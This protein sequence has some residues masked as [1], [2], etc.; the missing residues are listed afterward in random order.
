MEN[1]A[2]IQQVKQNVET[3]I[4]EGRFEEAMEKCKKYLSSFPDQKEIVKL[5][6]TIEE[7]LFEQ[8]EKEI[9]QKNK[10]SE[11]LYSAKDYLGALR[12]TKEALTLAPHNDKSKRLYLK[13]QE[14]YKAQMEEAEKSFIKQR[15]E[16]FE[17]LI[18]EEK[19]TELIEETRKLEEQNLENHAVRSLVE[20]FKEKLIEKE[21]KSKK[22][23]LNSDKIEDIENLIAGLKKI[24]ENS[25]LLR[26]L[27]NAVKQKKLGVQI[28]NIDEFIYEGQQNLVTLMKL[29]KFEESIRVCEEILKVNPEDSKARSILEKAKNSFYKQSKREAIKNIKSY[30]PTLKQEYKT[31]KDN[32]VTF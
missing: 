23:L 32:F 4:V 29:G 27:E 5:K 21:L 15:R 9:D 8:N 26:N 13:Y 31:G 11:K 25:K 17:Q 1:D 18:A 20:E 14:K 24:S 12:L 10:E 28:E 2:F 22:D 16:H 3:L 7:R 30:L 19:L 6:K